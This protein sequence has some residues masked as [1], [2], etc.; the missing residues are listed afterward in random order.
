MRAVG[1]SRSRRTSCFQQKRAVKEA[2]AR[3]KTDQCPPAAA[4]HFDQCRRS[5][6]RVPVCAL[7]ASQSPERRLPMCPF[8]NAR[9]KSVKEMSPKMFSSKSTKYNTSCL[10]GVNSEDE[11]DPSLYISQPPTN[12]K[13]RLV[14]VRFDD[15]PQNR[16]PSPCFGSRHSLSPF[17]T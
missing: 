13:G 1:T 8:R 11:V 9:T 3:R 6:R 12:G 2:Q 15:R 14:T 4:F 5:G 17:S 10:L 7:V 16:R